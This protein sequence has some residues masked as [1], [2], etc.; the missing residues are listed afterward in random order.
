MRM[1]LD[2]F[3][4]YA[5]AKVEAYEEA[6]ADTG[7]SAPERDAAVDRGRIDEWKA[8]IRAGNAHYPN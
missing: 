4:A 5:A 6:I 8:R 1:A 7:H 3:R 2:D